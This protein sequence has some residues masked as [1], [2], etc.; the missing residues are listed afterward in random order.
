MTRNDGLHIAEAA[1]AGGLRGTFNTVVQ[2]EWR[3]V[4]IVVAHIPGTYSDDFTFANGHVD[5]WY[6]GTTDNATGNAACLELA[7]I[8]WLA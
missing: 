6:Y 2:T 1:K 5:S 8:A 7:R 4:P 3:R